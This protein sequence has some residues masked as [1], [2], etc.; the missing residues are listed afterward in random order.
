MA[1]V[2]TQ[3]LHYCVW[4]KIQKEPQIY[5]VE[6]HVCDT[7]LLVQVMEDAEGLV[8]IDVELSWLQNVC[9]SVRLL[10]AA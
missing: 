8:E 1:H 6:E 4:L 5:R 7:E 2:Q 9:I 10:Q 3:L